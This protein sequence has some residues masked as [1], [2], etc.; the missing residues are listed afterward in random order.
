MVHGVIIVGK[1]DDIRERIS[2]RI[3]INLHLLFV[4]M[5]K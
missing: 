5:C 4:K 3:I 2:V 1:G